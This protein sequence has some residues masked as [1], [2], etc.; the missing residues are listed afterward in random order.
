M[1][2]NPP[3]P[4]GTPEGGG[5]TPPPPQNPYGSEPTTPP[6]PPQNPY[7]SQPPPPADP[8]A[9][10]PPAPGQTPYGATPQEPAPTSQNPYGAE[11]YP[12]TPGGPAP[13]AGVQ[14]GGLGSRFVARLIDGILFGI[15]GGILGALVG[16]RWVGTLIGSIL[17]LGYY[18][19]LESNRGQTLG[20]QIMKLRVHGASG[21][22]PTMEEAFRRNA[23]Y[24]LAIAA[25]LPLFILSLLLGLA[26]L[27][28]VIAIAVT[29]SQDPLKRGW[30]DK[31]GNTSVVKEG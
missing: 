9:G 12:V 27:V 31:F 5:S 4:S 23:F 2:E 14:P 24:L 19:Y 8:Y 7:A 21:G 30:H 26:S 6:P 18:V 3:P 29:I 15:L 10:N 13:V 28:A 20:K 16:E 11:A 17:Y 22:N 25:Y 1:T